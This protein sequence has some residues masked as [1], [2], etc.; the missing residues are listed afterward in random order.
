MAFSNPSS[1]NRFGGLCLG[2]SRDLVN[3]ISLLP[4]SSQGLFLQWLVQ[5]KNGLLTLPYWVDHLGSK[6]TR[7]QRYLLLESADLY[8]PP[9][10]A[11]TV[12]QT[13]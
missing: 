6:D 10:L 9:E 8:H 11:W 7:W 2:E 4:K 1:I 5:D 3:T 12:I 13:V